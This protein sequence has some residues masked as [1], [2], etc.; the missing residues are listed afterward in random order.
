[1]LQTIRDRATG[2]IAYTIIALLIIP[3]AL[4]GVNSYFGEP[5]VVNIAEV[6]DREISLQEFQL[7]YQR[8]RAQLQNLMGGQLDPSLFNETRL[9]YEVLRQLVD[10]AVL[11]QTARDKGLRVGDQ[12]LGQVIR[13]NQ[14]FQQDG[15]F[16]R[17]SYEQFLRFQQYTPAG[18]EAELRASMMANQLRSGLTDSSILTEAEV[19]RL[20]SLLKQQRT[21]S[22]LSLSTDALQEVELDEAEIET[23]FEE[24]QQ[25]FTSPEQLKV[26]YLDLSLDDLT[27]RVAVDE[28]QIQVAYE[29][30]RGRFT[31]PEERRAS[32]ILVTTDD[33]TDPAQA[34]ERAET[35]YQSIVDGSRSFDEVMTEAA[36]ADTAN[37][38]GGDLGAIAPG[39]M[40]PAFEQALFAMDEEGAISAPVQT[41][42][43][44][45]I[46]RLDEVIDEQVRP[47]AEV[48]DELEREL[49]LQAAEPQFFEAAETL[50]NMAFENPDSLE[51]AAEI[52][53]LR[54]QT[55]DWLTRESQE[56]IAALPGVLQAALSPEVLGQNFNSEPIEVNNDRVLVLRLEEY[57]ES[58]PLTLEEAREQVEQALREMRLRE[59]LQERVAELAELVR[60]GT[61][62]EELAESSAAELSELGA[63]TRDQTGVDRAVATEAFQ[64]PAPAPEG[65]GEVQRSVGTAP[66]GEDRRA[67]VVVTQVAPGD[68]VE[69][70]EGER[71]TLVERWQSQLGSN[72]FQSYLDSR[73]RQMDIVTYSDRL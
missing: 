43:G 58:A 34:R 18:F 63:I 4:W 72:Q 2:W 49:R 12:Q 37:L 71:E 66:L 29:E 53:D 39:M 11:E 44:L 50:A 26:R 19:N 73:R 24:N 30:Q 16:H 61:S 52:L 56:G 51:P 28:A 23:Y 70:P 68:P 46:I 1:M 8:Q 25:R 31:L 54:V 33:D 35:I 41:D 17:E 48:R 57:Q 40:A 55:S 21:V 36:S 6:G 9:R 45:H 7:A 65:E 60:E 5:P 14:T 10:D 62:L 27:D 64:L 47:L 59:K 20:L 15:R 69:V 67:V 38:E 42:F 13:A 22:Y 32:H 3:F